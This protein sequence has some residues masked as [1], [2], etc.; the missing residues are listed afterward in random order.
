M[1]PHFCIRRAGYK[2]IESWCA[3]CVHI[4]HIYVMV[5]CANTNVGPQLNYPMP[6]YAWC[7]M[8]FSASVEFGCTFSTRADNNTNQRQHNY[9]KVVYVFIKYYF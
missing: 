1:A 6:L 9:R 8:S 7:S 3:H 5:L 4:L 2:L